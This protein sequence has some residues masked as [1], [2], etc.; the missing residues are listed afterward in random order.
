MGIIRQ[1][2]IS[3]T[4]TQ[5]QPSEFVNFMNAML[6]RWNE[7]KKQKQEEEKTIFGAMAQ[8]KQLRPANPGEDPDFTY[9]GRG[10]KYVST[11]PDYTHAMDM[12]KMAG[13]ITKEEAY[14]RA[15]ELALNDNDYLKLKTEGEKEQWII[16]KAN[17]I[18]LSTAVNATPT[19]P[20]KTADGKEGMVNTYDL[21]IDGQR[22][23]P[24]Y[25]KLTQ[26]DL[27]AKSQPK[28]TTAQNIVNMA[29][30]P[31]IQDT[32]RAAVNL[33][34]PKSS[35]IPI[36]MPWAYAANPVG[37]IGIPTQ[38]VTPA[39]VQALSNIGKYFAP[40]PISTSIPP[41]TATKFLSGQYK[42]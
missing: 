34:M 32:R 38:N 41:E 17:S 37:N 28:T 3:V 13:G 40:Q 4:S 1:D 2:P 19:I 6:G 20:V 21:M 16:D 5:Q 15:T 11:A 42:R 26:A 36:K 27:D 23:K 14:K 7:Q 12:W 30:S 35:N 39:F 29:P 10:W 9:A 8:G 22:E 24:Q 18:Q 25:T 31:F 33:Q